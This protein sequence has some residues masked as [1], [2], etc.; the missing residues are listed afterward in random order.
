M[1]QFRYLRRPDALRLVLQ[2]GETARAL[3]LA[4]IARARQEVQVRTNSRLPPGARLHLVGV[5]VGDYGAAARHLRLDYADDDVKDVASALRSTQSGLYAEVRTQILT[6]RKATRELVLAA[7]DSVFEQLAADGNDLA[8]LHFSG[9]GALLGRAGRE[10]YYL[11]PHD[12][13][14]TN[15]Q[16]LRNSAIPVAELRARL[17]ELGQRARV[18][19]LLDACHAGAATQ[20]DGALAADGAQLRSALAGLANVTVL[21]SSG[22]QAPSLEHPDWQNG[23]FTEV[24]LRAL[25]RA[26][27]ADQ[28]GLISSTELTRYLSEHLPRL[29]GGAQ[30]PGIEVRF[31]SELFVSDL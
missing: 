10:Q 29:T 27:D 8:V 11:L 26:A 17:A 23:V 6:D 14:A 20:A 18:L 16:Q 13:D 7:L 28:N 15:R 19:V 12:A 3:G 22:S 9:H 2:E 31:D 30:Q 21:T 4:D 5:G 25:G 1:S 24:L